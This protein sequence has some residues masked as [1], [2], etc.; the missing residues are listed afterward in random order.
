M[1]VRLNYKELEVIRGYLG[2]LSMTFEILVPYLKG[3]HLV[4]AAH[5]DKRDE[6]GWKLTDKSWKR[7]IDTKVEEGDLGELE[8]EII[9]CGKPYSPHDH[10][11][12]VQPV[13]Q[14]VD[15]LRALH[16]FFKQ[17]KAP[18]IQD[19]CSDITVVR[20]GFGDAS[21][22]GFGSTIQTREGLKYRI[23]VW[24]S[25]DEEESS[26]YKELENVVSTIEEEGLTGNLNQSVMFFFTDNSTVEAALSKGNSTSRKLFDLVVRFRKLQFAHGNQVVVSHVSG[27]RM[28]AQGTDGVSRGN[29]MEGVGGGLDL[30]SFVPLH[31]TALERHPPLRGWME[32]WLGPRPEFL[33]PKDWFTRGH[34]HYGGSYDNKGF[35]HNMVKSGTMVWTPPPAAADVALEEL[36]RAVIKRQASTHVVVCPRLL[37][38]EWLRQLHKACDLVITIKAG[39][40]E[41]W[42]AEMFEPLI[43]GFVFPLLHFKPWKRRSTPQMCFMARKLSSMRDEPGVVTRNILRKFFTKQQRLAGLQ[44]N[45]VWKVL[46][47]ERES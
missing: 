18:V 12:E 21:G 14:L 16:E 3:F 32:G 1:D 31:L 42:P 27:K 25:D 20:Y 7:Y 9:L 13:Q 36:R 17:E 28:V 11:A 10:P 34:D 15:D 44:Q 41:G 46:Y 37:T 24:G 33:T 19:R 47:F 8:A 43:I 23:G 26:N 38:T 29:L 40:T 39:A 30:M 35:W 22:R 6:E 45:V 5:L 2:H 4:L